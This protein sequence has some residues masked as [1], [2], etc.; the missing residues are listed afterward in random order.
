LQ[1]NY[2]DLKKTVDFTEWLEYF[3]EGII[4]ELLRV[5][6]ELEK[7]SFGRQRIR[8]EYQ[9]I[10][11]YLNKNDSINDREYSKLTKRANSTRALDFKNM[12]LMG[13]L[14]RL[15]KGKNTYYKLKKV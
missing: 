5:Q 8:Q 14:E 11:D 6:K 13:F 2:Y 1:G 10:I 4:D 12:V 9:V 7:E 3:A 15:D